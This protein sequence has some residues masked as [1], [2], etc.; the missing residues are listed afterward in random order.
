M[1]VVAAASSL[2]RLLN[3]EVDKALWDPRAA[4]RVYR[5]RCRLRHALDDVMDM[6]RADGATE[7]RP[8]A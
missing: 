1:A 3:A 6:A 2:D 7:T 5:A 4:L 8:G